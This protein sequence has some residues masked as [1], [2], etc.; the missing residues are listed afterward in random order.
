MP[1]DWNVFMG[2]F[3]GWIDLILS[4]FL[5]VVA[6]FPMFLLQL[7]I[8]AF[9]PQSYTILFLVMVLPGW[10]PYCRFIRAEFFKLRNQ[11]FVQAAQVVGVSSWRLFLKHLFPNSLTPIITYIPFDISM[12]ITALG[13]LSFLGFG[14]PIHIASLGELLKQAREHFLHAWWL[15]AYPGGVL[16]MLTLS[17][18]LF[19]S[20]L[21]DVLDPRN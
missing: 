13:A 19:G 5:E 17:L 11:E 12:T 9:L 18:A 10:I 8:L 3:G 2:F 6:N 20:S 4:R 14:E 16:F 7:T 1:R 15:A 21:R